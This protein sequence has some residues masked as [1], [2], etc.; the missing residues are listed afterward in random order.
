MPQ[1]AYDCGSPGERPPPSPL[2]LNND[3][4]T[5]VQD[6]TPI[7]R[8]FSHVLAYLDAYADKQEWRFVH[9]VHLFYRL[10]EH[11]QQVTICCHLIKH[12]HQCT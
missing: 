12:S 4:C 11:P 9:L 7:V 8:L 6:R 2:R 5:R 10:L 1:E 3:A